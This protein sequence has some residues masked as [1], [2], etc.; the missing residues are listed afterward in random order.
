[1]SNVNVKKGDNVFVIAGKDKG[2]R[3]KVQ[4]VSPRDQTI[5]IEGINLAKKH[6]KP[7]KANP[8]GGVIDKAMPVHIAKIKLI[9]SGC[10]KPTRIGKDQAVDGSQVRVCRLCGRTL[11]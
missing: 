8:Q 11:D 2:R 3:G 4:R 7:T 6:A 9:C 10:D 5:I 1:M